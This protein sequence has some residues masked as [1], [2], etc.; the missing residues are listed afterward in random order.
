MVAHGSDIGAPS[1]AVA[2]VAQSVHQPGGDGRV[3]C[4]EGNL[5]DKKETTDFKRL[6]QR[7]KGANSKQ[8][9]VVII[10]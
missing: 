2:G 5:G 8:L 6:T 1:H 4:D 7:R 3:V 10:C 9:R